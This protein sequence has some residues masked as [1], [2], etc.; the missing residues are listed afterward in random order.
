MYKKIDVKIS[1]WGDND[2][3]PLRNDYSFLDDQDTCLV[4]FMN[5][6]IIEIKYNPLDDFAYSNNSNNKENEDKDKNRAIIESISETLH[7]NP[8]QKSRLRI[9]ENVEKNIFQEDLYAFFEPVTNPYMKVEDIDTY[10]RYYYNYREFDYNYILDTGKLKYIEDIYEWSEIN[11]M[12]NNDNDNNLLINFN[13]PPYKNITE[14]IFYKSIECSLKLLKPSKL[15]VKTHHFRS[16]N[17]KNLYDI[18]YYKNFEFVSQL[19]LI[20]YSKDEEEILGII[21]NMKKFIIENKT[22][23]SLSVLANFNINL[24]DF[25]I[26]YSNINQI[27]ITLIDRDNIE[28]KKDLLDNNIWNLDIKYNRHSTSF[29]FNKK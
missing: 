1:F 19:T 29:I 14:E 26:L 17:L 24:E 18:S 21:E 20:L 12:E 25:Y 5:G 8:S 27:S 13:N 3:K 4:R 2:K 15:G 6:E 7:L 23:T 10:D 22:L 28:I 9:V 16:F 11:D